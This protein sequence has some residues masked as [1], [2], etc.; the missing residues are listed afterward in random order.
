MSSEHNA[1]RP[2]NAACGIKEA[3]VHEE[4]SWRRGVLPE[5]PEACTGIAIGRWRDRTGQARE[6]SAP[7]LDT[8]YTIEVMLRNADVEFFRGG[9]RISKGMVGFGATQITAPGQPIR[10]SFRRVVEA[11]HLFVPRALVAK[12][13]Q[14]LQQ[15]DCAP[16]YELVDPAYSADPVMGKLAC[17]L[18]ETNSLRSPFASLYCASLAM[19]VLARAMEFR[20]DASA[21]SGMRNGLAP[22]RLRRTMQFIEDNLGEPVTLVDIAEHAGLSRMHFAAEFK[23]ATGLSPHAFLMQRRLDMAKTLLIEGRLPIVQIAFAVGFHSQAHF[24]TV[25]H[26]A[27][28]ITP[29]RWREQ[30]TGTDAGPRERSGSRGAGTEPPASES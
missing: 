1:T 11:I 13:Y 22:W 26:K 3:P 25:F 16:A 18:I 7:A 27:T 24:T 30:T 6:L 2:G 10:C 14:D 23:R 12:T 20:N 17:T 8:H 4:T 5:D 19:A 9:R 21:V 29:A 15:H 28:G